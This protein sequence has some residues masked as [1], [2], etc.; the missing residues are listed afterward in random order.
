MQIDPAIKAALRE[1][2]RLDMDLFS[3]LHNTI[4][5][6]CFA[7]NTIEYV[8]HRMKDAKVMLIPANHPLRKLVEKHVYFIPEFSQ[9][10]I[11]GLIGYWED[12]VPVVVN[13]YPT[14][15]TRLATVYSLNPVGD[16][17]LGTL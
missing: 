10:T 13:V 6:N 15:Q 8:I 9:P 12:G 16:H 2:D 7:Y 11:P 3:R 1:M 14:K 17:I 4:T 5:N